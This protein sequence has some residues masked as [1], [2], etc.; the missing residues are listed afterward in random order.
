MRSNRAIRGIERL[1][2]GPIA[3]G[4]IEVRTVRM[5]AL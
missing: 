5:A 2:R 3:P 4:S 1:H